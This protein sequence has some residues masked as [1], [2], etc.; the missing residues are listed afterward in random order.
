MQKGNSFL[1]LGKVSSLLPGSQ[2]QLRLNFC[3]V[4]AL[5]IAT[6]FDNFVQDILQ[7]LEESAEE[8]GLEISDD[9]LQR[10]AVEKAKTLFDAHYRKPLLALRYP[11]KAVLS[12]SGSK[13]QSFPSILL[14]LSFSRIAHCAKPNDKNLRKLIKE[15]MS[16]LLIEGNTAL[17]EAEILFSSAQIADTVNKLQTSCRYVTLMDNE[18]MGHLDSFSS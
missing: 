7:E 1:F 12:L 8:Q 15:T 17:T 11:P 10:Q 13:P 6:K 2:V 14:S 16:A 5:A 4:P 18:L 9:D 3:V